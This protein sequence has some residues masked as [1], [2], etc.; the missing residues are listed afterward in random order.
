[1]GPRTQYRIAPLAWTPSRS[2]YRLVEAVSPFATYVWDNVEKVL[3]IS[4]QYENATEREFEDTKHAILF[5]SEHHHDLM[6]KWLE[7]V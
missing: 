4:Q 3:M 2:S 6:R 7:E 1:M 5:A